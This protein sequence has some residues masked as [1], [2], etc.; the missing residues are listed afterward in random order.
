[1]FPMNGGKDYIDSLFSYPGT[2]KSSHASSPGRFPP[3]RRTS[4]H[5]NCNVVIDDDRSR[6]DADNL[7]KQKRKKPF[8]SSP[9]EPNLR[10]KTNDY[11]RISV[12]FPRLPDNVA[13]NSPCSVSRSTV[14]TPRAD[15]KELKV[16]IAEFDRFYRSRDNF[17]QQLD[18]FFS[19]FNLSQVS[20]KRDE[21]SSPLPDEDF[22]IEK[23]QFFSLIIALRKSTIRVVDCYQMTSNLMDADSS[24]ACQSALQTMRKHLRKMIDNPL[25]ASF[26][27]PFSSWIA[28]S[29]IRN[30]FFVQKSIDGVKAKEDSRE[31]R[32]NSA[33][34]FSFENDFPDELVSNA[35]LADKINFLSGVLWEI[36]KSC[37]AQENDS[38]M[39]NSITSRKCHHQNH[40]QQHERDQLSEVSTPRTSG[41]TSEE[42]ESR[43]ECRNHFPLTPLL[44]DFEQSLSPPKSAIRNVFVN[45]D[46]G[47]NDINL[48]LQISAKVKLRIKGGIFESWRTALRS[49]LRARSVEKFR[50]QKISRKVSEGRKRWENSKGG[51]ELE[52]E[53]H[54]CASWIA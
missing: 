11:R 47:R 26:D 41:L 7:K 27:E 42:G 48:A 53:R 46:A 24:A 12:S 30:P 9:V 28:V 10:L 17:V 33:K 6:C 25:F 52:R 22:S 37:P 40:L 49:S 18:F 45:A 31:G 5:R 50:V 29:P 4:L 15:A 14:L 43:S 39:S 20:L 2:T 34:Y 8:V 32:R 13:I 38:P 21:L 44:V 19:S 51:T 3:L 54:G 16:L 23:E 1:M 35:G 36:W